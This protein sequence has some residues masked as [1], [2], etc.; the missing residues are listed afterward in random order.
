V[1]RELV[2]LTHR[3][4]DM[5]RSPCPDNRYGIWYRWRVSQLQKPGVSPSILT[6][7]CSHLGYHHCARIG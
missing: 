2:F 5:S 4:L 3:S 6:D 1:E 7:S